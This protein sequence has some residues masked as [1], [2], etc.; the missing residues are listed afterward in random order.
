MKS[1][2]ELFGLVPR[3]ALDVAM[4]EE[5]HR[6][7]SRALHPDRHR[8]KP[9]AERRRL[10]E[11]AMRLNDAFR[12]LKDPL[13]RADAL[14]KAR[15]IEIA[16]GR[17]PSPPPMFLMEVI[18]EREALAAARARGD[19]TQVEST[20]AVVR[21]RRQRTEQELGEAFD[22][23]APAEQLLPLLATLR[24]DARFLEEA[25]LVLDELGD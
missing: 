13:R 16:E 6:D 20:L 17:E 21:A 23:E 3:Y 19:K 12:T 14:L 10:L 2:F 18:E 24:Y 4:L 7:V 11:E 9:P 5:R 8:D 15:G 25:R 1:P 22:R